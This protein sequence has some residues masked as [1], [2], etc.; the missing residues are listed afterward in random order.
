MFFLC[1]PSVHVLQCSCRKDMVKI[2]MDVFVKKFQP[3]R[4]E[5]WITGRDVVPIDHTRPTPEAREFLGE[6][7]ND[8]TSNSSSCSMEDGE[9]KRLVIHCIYILRVNSVEVN[10][11][12]LT[13]GRCRCF[14]RAPPALSQSAD[15]LTALTMQPL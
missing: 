9:R 1:L 5:Q 6:S 15:C 11:I 14:D 12:P 3:D 4:Y 10:G 2:S 7:F 13:P 8:L